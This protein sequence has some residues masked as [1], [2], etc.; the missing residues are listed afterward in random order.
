[1]PINKKDVALSVFGILAGLVLTYLL[2]KVSQRD[3]AANL[4]AAQNAA[5]NA[6][7]NALNQEQEESTI[8]S[9]VASTG[10]STVESNEGVTSPSSDTSSAADNSILSELDSIISDYTQGQGNQPSYTN[11][12]ECCI[13]LR[14]YKDHKL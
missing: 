10:S 1:M 9:Q 3:S 8:T 11:Q 2:W 4:L 12:K 14:Q 5:V 13:L 6:Q 7:N